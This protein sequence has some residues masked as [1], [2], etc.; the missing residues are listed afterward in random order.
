MSNNSNYSDKDYEYETENTNTKW[1]RFDILIGRVVF[2][3]QVA[4]DY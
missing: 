2:P 3:N 1:T 4:V